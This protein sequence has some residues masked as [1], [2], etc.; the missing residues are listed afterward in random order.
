MQLQCYIKSY[1]ASLL[2][3]QPCL[4]TKKNTDLLQNA[5]SEHYKE[6]RHLSVRRPQRKPVSI[7][8]VNAGRRQQT[9]AGTV[10][11][12]WVNT[13]HESCTH[14]EWKAGRLSWTRCRKQLLNVTNWYEVQ[15]HQSTTLRVA[16]ANVNGGP[17]PAGN[18]SAWPTEI[19]CRVE[20]GAVKELWTSLCGK[21]IIPDNILTTKRGGEKK[22]GAGR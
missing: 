20:E 10:V 5:T 17:P 1:A 22:T 2:S 8:F 6:K 21:V 18:A 16:R 4:E 9:K 13:E 3:F 11:C 14:T 19:L 15:H 7:E 12:T